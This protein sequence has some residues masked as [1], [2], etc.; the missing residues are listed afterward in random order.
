MVEKVKGI[1]VQGLLEKFFRSIKFSHKNEGFVKLSQRQDDFIKKNVEKC[2]KKSTHMMNF[3]PSYHNFILE[4]ILEKLSSR[5]IFFLLEL[6][7]RTTRIVLP[8]KWK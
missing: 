4:T 7:T 5:K 1:N 3:K 2:S 6:R 8:Q